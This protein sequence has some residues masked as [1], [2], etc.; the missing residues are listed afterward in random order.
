MELNKYYLVAVVM[1]LIHVPACSSTRPQQPESTIENKVPTD[2]NRIPET[3]LESNTNDANEKTPEQIAD[4][5]AASKTTPSA[6]TPDV[7]LMV[8]T[9][10]KANMRDH[11]SL[12]AK[13]LKT[14]KKGERVKVLTQKKGWFQVER[15]NGDVGW[16]YKSVLGQDG[17]H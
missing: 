1:F 14:L 16:C 9:G 4:E 7:I 8:V 11:P 2:A 17:N 10:N 3:D 12:K 5:E 6:A 13:I 15:D